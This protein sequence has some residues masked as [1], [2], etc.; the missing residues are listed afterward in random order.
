MKPFA[1][2]Q[3]VLLDNYYKTKHKKAATVP[4]VIMKYIL[5]FHKRV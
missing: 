2:G 1:T 3:R 4:T 5:Q